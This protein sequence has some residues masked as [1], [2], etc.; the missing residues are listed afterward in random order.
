MGLFSGKKNILG[1]DLGSTSIKVVELQKGK[2]VPSLVTYGYLEK[3]AG[4]IE[5]GGANELQEKSIESLKKLCQ[6]AAVTTNLAVTAIPNFSVFSSIINLPVIANKE[7]K[8]AVINQAKKIIP[9]PYDDIVL[10]WKILDKIKIIDKVNN[11]GKLENYRILINVVA[12]NLVKKYLEIF[13]KAGLQLSS[14]ETESFALSRSLV[15]NDPST[16]MIID[17]SA[18]STD[19][20][21]VEKCAPIFNRSIDVGGLTLTRALAEN[22]KIDF[23]KAEQFKRDLAMSEDDKVPNVIKNSLQSVID[24][25][26]YSL[27]IF[28]GQNNKKIEKIVLS[29]GSAYLLKLSDYFSKELDRKVFVSNPWKRI[30]YPAELEPALLEVAP[31][32]SV[33]IGLALK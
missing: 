14:L 5:R 3:A 23:K 24:E 18:V 13:E 21:I 19:V 15:G 25:I 16:I 7:L 27:N 20:V 9:L 32:F 12:K 8:E 10:D 26:K 28:E 31:R 1:I 29:G 2:S 22:F 17:F 30:S 11:Q 4:D 6:R 33:A